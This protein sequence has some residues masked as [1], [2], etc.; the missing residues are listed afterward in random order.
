MEL[1]VNDV[2]HNSDAP[3]DTPALY[4]LRNDLGLV[5]VRTGC[6]EGH[7]GACTVL[8][9]GQPTTTCDLPLW[10]LAGKTVR[11]PE[12]LGTPLH[13]HPVQAALLAGQA[14]QCGYCPGA[15]RTTGSSR[16]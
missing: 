9:D 16:P 1:H 15:A 10:A 7:C 14:A 13:P 6:G 2:V 5:G 4:V 8:V 11:T 12:G 3:P